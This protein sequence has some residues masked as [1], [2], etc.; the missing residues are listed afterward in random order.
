MKCDDLKAYLDG[1]LGPFGWLMM[2]LHMR[3]CGA[4]RMNAVEWSRLSRDIEQLEGEPVQP[5]LRERLV[6]DAITAAASARSHELPHVPERPRAQGVWT[7]RRVCVAAAFAVLMIAF[8]L[9]VLPR[10]K[11]N[12]ALADMAIAMAQVSTVHF[13]GFAVDSN[14]ERRGLEGWVK[15]TNRLRIRVDGKEDIA[16][17]GGRLIAVELDRLPK[18]TIRVSGAWPGL[19]EGMTYLDLFSAPG[20]L[21]SAM[22]G[23]GAKVVSTDKVILDGGREGVATEL[24]GSDGARMR[25]FTDA[26]TNLVARSET[27]SPSGELIESILQVEYD[28]PVADSVFKMSIP[29]NLPVVDLIGPRVGV[30]SGNYDADVASLNTDPNARIVLTDDSG[31]NPGSSCGT[32]CHPDFRFEVLSRDPVAIYYLA[33]RNVY[34]ILGKARAYNEREHWYSEPVENGDIRLPGEPQIEDVLMLNG[35]PGDYCG[36]NPGSFYRFQNVGAGPATVTYHTIKAAYV[37][38]G[39]VKVL[40]TG[41]VYTNDVVSL[42]AEFGRDIAE[43]INSAG[44]L[45][46]GSLPP[47]EIESMRADLDVALRLAAIQKNK[48]F[49]G[50]V[51]IDGAEVMGQYGTG[52]QLKNG[53]RFE[54]AGPGTRIWALDIPAKSEYYVIGRVR[55]MPANKIVKNGIV[56]YDG[57]IISSEE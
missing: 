49:A 44:K 27:Y 23:N 21:R 51:V 16:D 4:C 11:E 25:I 8:G 39:T 31:N 55:L 37:M 29:N 33:D 18:V 30:V 36:T 46:W 24:K 17:D 19:A 1:E 53:L 41:K 28:V 34:R 13:T 12:T 43:Y 14:G 52:S 54:A 32:Y 15:G 50:H 26:R 6:A 5:A 47:S 22:A 7:M 45:D 56:S 42:D 40:P 57:E 10:Q 2:R 48:N 20:S 38:R 35:R 9:W 3:M